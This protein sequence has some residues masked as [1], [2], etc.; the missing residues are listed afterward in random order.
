MER[1]HGKVAIVSG[2][3]RGMGASHVRAIVAEGGR[4][5]IGDVR[6]A[7]GAAFPGELGTGALFVHLDVDESGF[8]TGV[9]ALT[10]GPR[11][12]SRGQP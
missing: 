9:R 8:T 5:V 6:D 12:W 11:T 1:L 3:A 4:V 10:A 7:E 2:A